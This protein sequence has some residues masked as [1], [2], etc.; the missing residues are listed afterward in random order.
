MGT[1]RDDLAAL[2]FATISPQEFATIVKGLSAGEIG[3]FMTGEFRDRVLG[4]VFSRMERQFRPEAAGSLSALI[5]WKITGASDAV[6]ETAIDAGACT[7]REGRSDAEPRVSLVMGDAE[8]LK[9]VSGNGSPV[10]MFMT[11]RLKV[12]GDVGM[13]SGLTRLFDIPKA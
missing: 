5:R 12:A 6:Y 9:L 1:S 3:Q 8:F 11:R 10:T 4:A 2:D 13:A 7:V